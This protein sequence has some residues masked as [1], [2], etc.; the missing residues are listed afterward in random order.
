MVFIVVTYFDGVVVLFNSGIFVCECP[1]RVDCPWQTLIASNVDSLFFSFVLFFLQECILCFFLFCFF[2][3]GGPF[4][5]YICVYTFRFFFFCFTTLLSLNNVKKHT[6]EHEHP[7]RYT[8][9]QNISLVDSET[10]SAETKVCKS[11][12][13]NG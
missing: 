2:L 9:T 12:W 11:S 8:N 1:V 4:H 10:L 13:C 6:L 3:V 7:R 5:I